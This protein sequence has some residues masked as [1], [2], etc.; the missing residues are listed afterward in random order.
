MRKSA[1]KQERMWAMF[2]HLA[3]FLGLV[4]P[5]GNLLGPFIIWLLRRED[6]P[7]VNDQGKESL[8]FQISMTIYIVVG[9]LLTYIFIGIP[10]LIALIIFYFVQVIKASITANNGDYYRYPFTMRFI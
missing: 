6:F 1:H 4:F 7:L 9:F 10:I 5:F 2:C 8:S 3:S